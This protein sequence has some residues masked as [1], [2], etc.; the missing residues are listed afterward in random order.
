MRTLL[1]ACCQ[2]PEKVILTKISQPKNVTTKFFAEKSTNFKLK[3]VFCTFPSLTYV[4]YLSIP[5]SGRWRGE[6]L[7]RRKLKQRAPVLLINTYAEE[8]L[9]QTA[10][11]E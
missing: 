4:I 3:K 2:L 7:A 1:F 10:Y 9:Y 5:S 6:K 11:K 8:K